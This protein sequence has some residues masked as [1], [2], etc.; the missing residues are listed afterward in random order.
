[1]KL[2]TLIKHLQKL[3]REGHG[4]KPVIVS[5]MQC[6]SALRRASIEPHNDA[7]DKPSVIFFIEYG[8]LDD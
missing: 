3:E 1:M 5:D 8:D 2:R 7:K 4:D 6:D